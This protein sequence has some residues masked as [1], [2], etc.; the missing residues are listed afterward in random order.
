[1]VL[2]ACGTLSNQKIFAPPVRN[3]IPEY[4]ARAVQHSV[5][6]VLW[7]VSLSSSDSEPVEKDQF[8]SPAVDSDGLRVFVGS[9][10]GIFG[11]YDART[12]KTLWTNLV[13]GPFDATPLVSDGIVYAGTGAGKLFAWRK[14]DG[15]LL[16]SYT[17]S[18][19]IDATPLLESDKLIIA[20]DSNELT[21]LDSMTGKWFWTYKRDVPSGKFQLK[22]ISRPMVHDGAVFVGFSDGSVAKLSLDDGS[23]LSLKKLSKSTDGFSDVDSEPVFIDEDTVLF[24]TYSEGLVAMATSDLRIK[25]THKAKIISSMAMSKN[26]VVYYSTSDSKIEAFDTKSKRLIW[27]FDA[28]KGALS[29]P[30]ITKTW[31]M[32]S[33]G[34]HS[35]LVLDA[36]TGQ[37]LQVFNPGKGS[38]SAPT[39]HGNKAFWISNGQTLYGMSLVN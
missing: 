30:I 14:T 5:L 4:P 19:S 29:K 15:G 11:C 17:A 23:V 34:E 31:I 26:G 16:W 7:R 27:R 35:L 39:I 13:E 9:F 32:V 37:L 21:C 20:T 38:N 18:S 25:W 1:M 28:R 24:G 10:S 2:G 33:S 8:S 36:R 12:G 6:S 22:G 3:E